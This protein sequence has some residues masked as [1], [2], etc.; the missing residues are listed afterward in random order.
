M[1]RY[2]RR[3]LTHK[4]Q[5]GELLTGLGSASGLWCPVVPGRRRLASNQFPL[6]PPRGHWSRTWTVHDTESET[7]DV[8]IAIGSLDW[9]ELNEDIFGPVLEVIEAAGLLMDLDERQPAKR[10]A[11]RKPA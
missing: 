8:P 6:F 5:M 9:I 3:C 1:E 4:A 2:I 10:V 11:W 7:P